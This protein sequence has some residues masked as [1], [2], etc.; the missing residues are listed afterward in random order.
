MKEDIEQLYISNLEAD[1]GFI[2]MDETTK[3]RNEDWLA[4]LKKDV[5]IEEA[6]N[7][8]QDMMNQEQ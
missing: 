8:M 3:A 6:L 1:L 5:Y 4:A 2:N 7:I